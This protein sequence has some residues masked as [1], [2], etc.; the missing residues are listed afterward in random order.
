MFVEAFLQVVSLAVSLAPE[1]DDETIRWAMTV[2]VRKD[3]AAFVRAVQILKQ[4]KETK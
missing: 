4:A 2:D 3:Q 1:D